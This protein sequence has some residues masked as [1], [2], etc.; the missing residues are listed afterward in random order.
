MRIRLDAVLVLVSTFALGACGGSAGAKGADDSN[1]WADFKG[2]YSQ[3]GPGKGTTSTAKNESAARR[4]AKS[5][6]PEAKE[7]AAEEA[8]PAKKTSKSTIKGESIST[9]TEEALADA[10]KTALK[11]KLLGSQSAVG[12]QYETVK[13]QLKGAVVTIVRP[14]ATP[15]ANGA[16]VDAPKSRNGSLSKAEAGFYDE[17]ADVLVIVESGKKAQAQKALASI[18]SR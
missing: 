7:A 1:M 18:V 5:G 11:T 4:D 17:D 2:T 16:P 15:N 6:K 9:I 12:P 14:A 10:S 8:A 3:P 13:V